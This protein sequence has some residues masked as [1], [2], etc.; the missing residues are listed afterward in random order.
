MKR[1]TETDKWR[2]SFYLDLHPF[3]KLLL[4][5]L[6]DSCDDAGFIDYIPKLWLTH[7]NGKSE[8]F[9]KENLKL[10][11]A[12][13]QSKLLSDKKTK[14]FIKDYLLH[15]KK[16]PLIK[17]KDDHDWIIT[18]LTNN[19]E[20][21]GNPDEIKNL[22]KTVEDFP[23]IDKIAPK[24]ISRFVAPEYEAF[25]EYFLTQKPDVDEDKI[26]GLFD[27]YVSCGWK[28]GKNP[29]KDWEAAIR[30][31]ILRDKR[32][33]NEHATTKKSRTETTMSVAEELKASRR[34]RPITENE[35]T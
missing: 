23:K 10:A 25:K 19:L 18:K 2:D 21:F 33:G 30:N 7:L 6:Y 27:H 32:V 4:S 8:V 35:P 34:N 22:L 12:E 9:T 5:Y 16:I 26:R 29:M 24:K 13:L 28:V 15:Q 3:S 20:K 17:G 11:L 31:S 1:L 14:L